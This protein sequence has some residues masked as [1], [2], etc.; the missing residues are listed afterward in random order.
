MIK[1][2]R[3]VSLVSFRCSLHSVGRC[4]PDERTTVSDSDD[5]PAVG[6]AFEL[7]VPSAASL[8]CLEDFHYCLTGAPGSDDR[9]PTTERLLDMLGRHSELER[10]DSSDHSSPTLL[11]DGPFNFAHVGE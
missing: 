2:S 8:S 11:D 7:I 5:F 6:L 3:I 10:C 9:F 4:S 1:R